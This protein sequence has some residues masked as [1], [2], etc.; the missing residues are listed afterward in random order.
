MCSSQGE[1]TITESHGRFAT[2]WDLRS[3][4]MLFSTRTTLGQPCVM[5]LRQESQGEIFQTES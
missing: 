3:Y 2:L 5:S 4:L 1:E